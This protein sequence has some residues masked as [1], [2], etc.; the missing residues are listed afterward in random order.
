MQ[1][2]RHAVEQLTSVASAS[3]LVYIYI[4]IYSHTAPTLSL[5]RK[6]C[7]STPD[8]DYSSNNNDKLGEWRAACQRRCIFSHFRFDFILQTKWPTD[9]FPPWRR[10]TCLPASVWVERPTYCLYMYEYMYVC[11]LYLYS[12]LL[13]GCVICVSQLTRDPLALITGL[14]SAT[15][16]RTPAIINANSFVTRCAGFIRYICIYFTDSMPP[17][18]A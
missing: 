5:T 4:Y 11:V 16:T 6:V 3:I 2:T 14:W 8:N 10:G 7:L 17:H 1:K 9:V 18:V 13:Y 12:A 15:P